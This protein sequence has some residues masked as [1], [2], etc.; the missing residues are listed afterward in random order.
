[1]KSNLPA[2]RLIPKWRPI[3]TTLRTPDAV[4]IP[5]AR[6]QPLRC[7]REEFDRAVEHWRRTK[8]PGALG[9]VLSF[10]V[11]QDLAEEVAALGYEA[12]R[13]GAS[14]TSVQQLLIQDIGKH[15]GLIPA[16]FEGAV[17]SN[18]NL[19]PFQAPIRAVRALLKSA[20]DNALALLD[21]AQFQAAVGRLER[22]ERAIR[23]ALSLR[24]DNRLVLR[25]AARFFVHAGKAD[26]GHALIRRHART[27]ADP[28][29]M[30]SE[31]ALADAAKTQSQ[32]LGKGKRFLF[33]HKKIPAAQITE[34][35]GA[36]SMAELA[37]G[38][39][40][41]A[42]ETQRQ[43]LLAPN[44]NVIAQAIEL[45]SKLG[46]Q[47]DG[48]AIE[49]AIAASSEARV[50]Q[51]WV[52]AA[53]DDVATYAREWH[54]QEPFS[55]RP[56]QMLSTLYAYQGDHETA[57]RWIR[58]GLLADPA[59]QGLLINLAYVQVLRRDY[60]AASEVLRKHRSSKQPDFEPFTLAT[61]GLMAYQLGEFAAGDQF[62]NAAVAFLD[63]VKRP[64]MSAYC[65][66]NQALAAQDSQHPDREALLA[67]ASSALKGNISP[68]SAMLLKVRTEP[69][70]DASI[71]D[72]VPGRRLSQWVFDP[73]SN[74]LTERTGVTSVGAKG[75][76]VNNRK[77]S[78]ER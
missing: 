41:R 30:A 78:N 15:Q 46:L 73:K 45:R 38:N 2:R 44:D 48:V 24:P 4:P 69:L 42:R 18:D 29:L 52:D 60:V 12:L 6:S 71:P 16:Q 22:A 39:L 5:V 63:K 59:D 9:D 21:Y 61:E 35:A 14:L 54:V 7:D 19:H 65:L 55:S 74:T 17:P 64:E 72:I 77:S 23:T 36:V 76:V 1:M 8:T 56:V 75:L 3:A 58:A 31:I 53:P 62:Y 34:L 67:K 11:H 10:G 66:L 32:F 13:A 49:R 57:L 33:D 43:A 20:P 47:L 40:K 37:S 68:D 25:T 51:A 28:W 26:V 50:L 27:I 70:V